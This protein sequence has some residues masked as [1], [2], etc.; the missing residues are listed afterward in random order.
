MGRKVAIIGMGNVGS[1]IAHTLLLKKSCDNLIISS[2]NK[3]MLYAQML[4]LEHASVLADCNTIIEERLYSEYKDVDI[5]VITAAA[6]FVLGQTRLDMLETSKEIVKDIIPQIMKSGFHGIII[7]VTNPVDIVSYLVYKYSGLSE[8]Q[9]FG[10][11]TFLDT[12]RLEKE[13]SKIFN[14]NTSDI[15]TYIVGEHGDSQVISWSNT[16]IK[17]ENIEKVAKDYGLQ[18]IKNMEKQLEKKIK[19]VGWEIANCK[20]TTTYGIA[21]VVSEIVDCIF[22]NEKKVFTLSTLDDAMYYSMPVILGRTG[23]Q[24]DLIVKY[25]REELQKIQKSK[26]II[27]SASSIE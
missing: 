21:N 11:G 3:K 26:S 4:D 27:K 9:V 1:T 15:S 7:V 13:I 16:T 19:N 5:I 14:V 25:T 17:G 24:K 8:R 23:I 12:I 20:G 2:R 10:T 22:N 6:P 18:N